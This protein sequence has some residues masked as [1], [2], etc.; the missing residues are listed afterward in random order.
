VV[1]GKAGGFQA[2]LDLSRL[3]GDDGF[4]VEGEGNDGSAGAKVA[5]A[6]D[7][8]GDGLDDL[9]L[10]VPGAG[11][12]GAGA[13]YVVF[14]QEGGLGANVS[15]S[16]LDGRDGFQ[17]NGEAEGD[18]SG[19]SVAS[20]GDV[21]GDGFADLIVGA[22]GVDVNGFNDGASYVV[23]GKAQGF[24]AE[25]DLSALNGRNG[26]Q[27]TGEAGGDNSGFPDADGNGFSVAS[28]GDVNGDGFD[29]VI[30]GAPG[31]YANGYNSGASYVVF[32]RA[33]GFEATVDL[34]DLDG[35]NGF[36]IDGEDG[37]DRHRSAV[38]SAGDL[39]GDG[40]DDLIV[41][42]P[43]ASRGGDYGFGAAYVIFGQA[44]GGIRR[45]GTGADDRLRGTEFDDT[46]SGAGGDDRLLGGAGADKL[47]GGAGAD[48]LSG[49]GG[50]D[51]FV[52][53]SA[54]GSPRDGADTILD[55]GGS[56]R[57]D[58]RGIDADPGRRGDQ[59]FDFIGR[60]RF[61]GE[62]GEVMVRRDGGD[63]LV[64]ADRHSDRRADL[65]I[66]IEGRVTLDAG[67]FLL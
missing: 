2:D 4:T 20:A 48:V 19:F 37:G 16:T 34:A 18:Y 67:D 12:N 1:F 15:L 54:A 28:A 66:V 41:G 27:I 22:T 31:N 26:F 59:A 50:A 49:G 56:D 44:T 65:E 43:G 60:D 9:I 57:I 62:E 63:T 29:D 42:S 64:L 21:N 45:T 39:N 53:R 58:L 35:S 52:F 14:G 38:A 36:R 40:F 10:G 33:G 23:F 46:L 51:R 8:N 25:I 61:T 55:F 30:I 17:I 6:G 24:E 7:M 5:S 11:P 3:D 32:G 47:D 13:S